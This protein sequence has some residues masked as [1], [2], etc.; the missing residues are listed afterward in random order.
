VDPDRAA[1]DQHIYYPAVLV[2][3]VLGLTT[4]YKAA[5]PR[6]LPW[7]RLLPGALLAMAVFAI[8][9]TGLRIYIAAI[10]STGYTYGALATPIAFLLFAFLIG[11]AIV[12]GAQ[13]NNAIQEIWPVRPSRWRRQVQRMLGLRQL[14]E[15]IGIESNRELSEDKPAPDRAARPRPPRGPVGDRA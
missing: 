1:N 12:L 13:L 14:A 10:T 15:T 7:R 2:V 6:S 8:S 5:L 11:F 9:A 3:I 4:L